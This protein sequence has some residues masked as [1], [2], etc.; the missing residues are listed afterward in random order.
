VKKD[1]STPKFNLTYKFDDNHMVYATYSRGFRPGGINRRT[2]APPAPALATYDPDFLKNYEVGFKTSWLNNHVRFNGAFFWEDWRS[3]QFGFLGQ[4]S[5][6]IIRNAGSAR[7]K[8][9]EQELEWAVSPGF[10]LSVAATE[11]DPKLNKDFCLD[12]DPATG[13]P[14]PLSTC[15]AWDAVP[16]GT[17]LPTTPKFKGNVTARYTFAIREAQAHLQGAYV[18]QGSSNSQLAPAAD[19]LIGTQPAYGIFDFAGGVGKGNFS[20]ELFVDNVF[21]KR[22][23]LYRFAECTIFGTSTGLFPGVP[24]CGTKPL[25]NI[26]APRMVGLRFGQRF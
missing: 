24:I 20:A 17:Q 19:A 3:F 12:T 7:I 5:F 18:Y 22:V 2:Q 11:L 16:S 8:G 21:D 9:A 13:T 15:P 6:T 23:E 1:G 26:N 25:A 10:T 4:N 14:F